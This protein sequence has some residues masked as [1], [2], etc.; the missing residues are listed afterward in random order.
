MNAQLIATFSLVARDPATGDLGVAV[1]SKFLAV[2]A[3][4]PVAV[5]GVGAVATQALANTS[6]GPRALDIL[7]SGGTPDDCLN[8]FEAT[9]PDFSQRQF[10]IVTATGE[11]LTHTGTACLDWAGGTAGPDFAAQGN[12]LTGPEVVEALQDSWEGSRSVP[13]PERLLT[14]LA[15]ADAAG[16]DSRGRQSA[17]LY[18]VGE[19]KGYGGFTDR[20]ID[21]RVDDH[22]D[23][24]TELQ[25]LLGLYRLVLDRPHEEPVELSRSQIVWLQENL[26][27]PASGEWDTATE[28]RLER[29]FGIENLEARWLGGPRLDPQALAHLR[30]LFAA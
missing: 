9:D 11:S 7:Q 27:L 21:L 1:A 25:R 15:A 28:A 4:V 17:A 10:G 26:D 12:I 22:E 29:L 5:A 24:V 13:F 8:E 14:A 19:G 20:W 18:V 2:G 3:V 6:Y 16:G 30:R 23:P